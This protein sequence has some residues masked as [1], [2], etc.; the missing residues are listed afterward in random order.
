MS[1]LKWSIQHLI[2]KGFETPRLDAELLLAHALGCTRVQLYTQ[3]EKPLTEEERGRFRGFLRRRLNH[4][5]IAYIAGYREFYGRRFKV[6]PSVLIPR[7]DTE[8]LIEHVL[9]SAPDTPHTSIL[10]LCTGSG[11]IAVTLAAELPGT[12]VMAVDLSP[13][14]LEVARDNAAINQVADQLVFTEWDVTNQLVDMTQ[15]QFDWIVSNPPYI[16]RAEIEQL[17]VTVKRF[18]PTLALDGGDDGLVFYRKIIPSSLECL[19]PN[20]RLAVEVGVNQADL[21]AQLF[22]QAGFQ[23]ISRVKDLAGTVRVVAGSKS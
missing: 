3:F 7:P 21:V 20:G 23:N 9:E 13:S 2:S 6:S 14:A 16:P 17:S 22:R 5:P 10:D 15:E 19:K 8:T 11:C 12:R 4:E 18:E 1:V